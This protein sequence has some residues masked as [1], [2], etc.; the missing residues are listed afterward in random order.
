[1]SNHFVPAMLK[2]PGDDPRRDLADLFVVASPQSPGTRAL[3][4][5]VNP[6]SPFFAGANEFN[7]GAPA[8]DVANYQ[9]RRECPAT[10]A[11]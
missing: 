7:A 4:F 6:F 2:F 11:C 8:Y 9:V 1:M 5:R 3:S 10:Y